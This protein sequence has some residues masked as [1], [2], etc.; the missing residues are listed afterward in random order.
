MFNFIRD[1]HTANMDGG[2]PMVM[3]TVTNLL[4]EKDVKKAG[5]FIGKVKKC[6]FGN[7]IV[8]NKTMNSDEACPAQIPGSRRSAR[9][10]ASA[11]PTVHRVAAMRAV[12]R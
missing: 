6:F 9:R 7:H 10:P 12:D 1:L 5:E 8:A 2:I 4:K 3:E 11:D